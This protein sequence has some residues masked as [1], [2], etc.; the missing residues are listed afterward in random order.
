[1]ILSSPAWS[2][3]SQA[4]SI[5]LDLALIRPTWHL[6]TL[7]DGCATDIYR[8]SVVFFVSTLM[9]ILQKRA[10]KAAKRARE[11]KLQAMLALLAAL[12]LLSLLV[13]LVS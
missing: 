8:A 4:L 1:M 2:H 9:E 12:T 7:P 3:A 13:R 11:Q 6:Q 10:R 5:N